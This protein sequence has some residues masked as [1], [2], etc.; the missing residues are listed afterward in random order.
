MDLSFEI[1]R[2]ES[3]EMTAQEAQVFRIYLQESGLLEIFG[4]GY[5]DEIDVK[6]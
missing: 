5:N 6:N 4:I 1:V 2:Y 3:G